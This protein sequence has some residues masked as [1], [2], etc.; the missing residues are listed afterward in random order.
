VSQVIGRGRYARETYPSAA[1]PS[2]DPTPFLN[3][4]AWFQSYHTGDDGN[5]GKTALTPVKRVAEIRRRW[6]GG[7][8]G[9]RPTLP[10]IDIS[11]TVMD[12][13]TGSTVPPFS[14]PLCALWDL[15]M[16][17][18]GS[19]VIDCQTTVVR[20][21]TVTTSPNAFA[22]TSTGQQTITDAGVA[23]WAASVDHLLVDTTV[24]GGAATWVVLGPGGTATLSGVRAQTTNAA[25]EAS[26]ILNNGLALKTVSADDQ[27]T[28]F[29]LPQV[30]FGTESYFALSGPGGAASGT[31]SV[32]VRRGHGL[33]ASQS[34]YLHVDC[35]AAF[36]NNLPCGGSV[37]FAECLFDQPRR[38]EGGTIF[39]NCG[40][41]SSPFIGEFFSGVLG[42]AMA[43]LS[44]Y[45]RRNILLGGGCAVDQ[46]FQL[47]GS[48]TFAGGL[49]GFPIDGEVMMGNVGRFLNGAAA[50]AAAF[51]SGASAF[52]HAVDYDAQAIFYGTTGG[53]P[54]YA[55]GSGSNRGGGTV[56]ANASA[57]TTFVF[58]GGA[59]A[60]FT[61]DNQANGYGMNSATGALVGPTTVTVQHLD[62]ALAAGTGLGKSALWPPSAS[63]ISVL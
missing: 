9:V 19:L 61:M 31:A 63:R 23:S 58:D 62:A 18:G 29:D 14:D 16:A 60:T 30:Y 59:A 42:N 48:V 56:T 12:S 53:S 32:L 5:D 36:E 34:D 21:G 3:Q 49:G 35:T 24:A 26:S 6:N 39:A 4:T 33:A 37:V 52:E 45:S 17:P 44:G 46:D 55:L 2:F 15:D 8:A 7:I 28:L 20:N 13:V 43:L 10:A 22:R 1:S 11:V 38:S 41:P 57:A 50:N 47:Y 51:L 40:V 25:G 54:I 27:Y